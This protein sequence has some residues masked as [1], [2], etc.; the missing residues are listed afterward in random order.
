MK[1]IYSSNSP[2]A[3]KFLKNVIFYELPGVISCMVATGKDFLPILWDLK[4][5]NNFKL[6]MNLSQSI[7][8]LLNK[9]KRENENQM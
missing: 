9:A 5:Q 4:E 2:T 3:C 8:T 1:H 6:V 7:I